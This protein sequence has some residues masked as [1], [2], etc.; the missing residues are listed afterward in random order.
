MGWWEELECGCKR[1]KATSPVKRVLHAFI[2]VYSNFRTG[3]LG[4][5]LA[6]R[7][8]RRAKTKTLARWKTH[9]PRIECNFR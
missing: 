2:Q 3:A 7:L 4:S 8:T 9:P 6:A 5:Y 1:L